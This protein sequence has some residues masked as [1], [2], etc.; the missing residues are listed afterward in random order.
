MEVIQVLIEVRV[1]NTCKN[2]QR[3]TLPYTVI[4]GGRR[5]EVDLCMEDAKP[6]EAVLP[7]RTGRKPA[8]LMGAANGT[9]RTAK[10]AAAKRTT[11]K[12]AAR[13]TPAAK[14]APSARAS[15]VTPISEIGNKDAA[16]AN[17]KALATV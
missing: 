11:K 5:E 10:K 2:P 16:K 6:F 3:G 12:A 8:A 14:K 4:Q 13:K 7:G 1:C 9:P 15:R 17:D